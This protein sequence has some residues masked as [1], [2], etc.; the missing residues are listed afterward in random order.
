ML[1]GSAPLKPSVRE[2]LRPTH[3]PPGAPPSG[4]GYFWIESLLPTGCRVSL[5]SVSVSQF[6]T[7]V[8]YKNYEF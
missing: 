1:K 4:H 3:P 8:E 2:G 7:N 5:V 6:T